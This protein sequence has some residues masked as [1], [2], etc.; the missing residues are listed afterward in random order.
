VRVEKDIPNLEAEI[1][2]GA[3]FVPDDKSLKLPAIGGTGLGQCR[4]KY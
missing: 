4:C 2:L 3:T 1:V